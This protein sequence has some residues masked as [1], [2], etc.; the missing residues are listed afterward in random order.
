MCYVLGKK[1]GRD[2]S[3]KSHTG[4]VN[5]RLIKMRGKENTFEGMGLRQQGILTFETHKCFTTFI[6]IKQK[7]IKFKTNRNK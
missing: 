2:I 1:K 5:Q 6:K 3:V 7:I 4:K